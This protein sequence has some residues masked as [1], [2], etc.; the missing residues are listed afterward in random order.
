MQKNAHDRACNTERG[1]TL[2]G[3]PLREEKLRSPLGKDG[4]GREPS[5]VPGK[6]NDPDVYPLTA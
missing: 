1:A 3:R 6:T 2:V 4:A 5:V